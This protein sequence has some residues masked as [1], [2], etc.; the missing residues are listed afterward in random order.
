ME[1]IHD[2]DKHKE[3]L[4]TGKK[5]I[6][7]RLFHVEV[8]TFNIEHAHL[9]Y[10]HRLKLDEQSHILFLASFHIICLTEDCGNT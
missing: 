8:E 5:R 1:L 6:A 10:I 2:M 9:Y 4:K 3:Y 7:H